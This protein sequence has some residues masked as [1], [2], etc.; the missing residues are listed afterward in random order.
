MHRYEGPARLEWWANSSMCIGEYGVDL[1]VTIDQTGVWRASARFAVE[2]D[3]EGREGWDFLMELD[4]HFSL[5][6]PGEDRGSLLVRV[7]EA[8]DGTLNLTE[9]RN[10][11]GSGSVSFDL[12]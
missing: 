7:E 9:P 11:D 3:G 2:L 12:T 6:F 10:W 1:T 5:A 4:P 8:R